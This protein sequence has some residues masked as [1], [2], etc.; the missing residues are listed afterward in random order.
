MN[1]PFRLADT[2]QWVNDC[3]GDN[4]VANIK[5]LPSGEVILNADH[6]VRG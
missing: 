5:K 1:L 3:Q 6:S 4:T 2:F